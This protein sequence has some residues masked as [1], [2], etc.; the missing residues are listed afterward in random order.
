MLKGRNPSL[1]KEGRKFGESDVIFYMIFKEI[2]I[3]ENVTD[4]GGVEGGVYK[5]RI[6]NERSHII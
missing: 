1:P 4:D 6:L 2:K 3:M 5:F